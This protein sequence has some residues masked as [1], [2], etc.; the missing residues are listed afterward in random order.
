MVLSQKFSYSFHKILIESLLY[1]RYLLYVRFYCS[2]FE[3]YQQ[4]KR[5]TILVLMVHAW[6]LVEGDIQQT[7]NI[8]SV[9]EK[10]AGNEGA[11]GI[12]EKYNFK[13]VLREGFIE[14][15]TFEQRLK[16]DG[17]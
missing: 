15:I 11:L 6:I 1:A 8:I 7:L 10:K 4:I 13:V 12:S 14:K 17:S 9:T 3:L 2:R 5:K 16:G